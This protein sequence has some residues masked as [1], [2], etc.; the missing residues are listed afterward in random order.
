MQHR[1]KVQE[2]CLGEVKLK[3]EPERGR[4]RCTEKSFRQREQ[5]I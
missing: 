3:D 2:G 4:P 1:L 5:Y